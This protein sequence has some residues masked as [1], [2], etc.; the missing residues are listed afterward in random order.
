MKGT[1]AILATALSALLAVSALSGCSGPSDTGNSTG[2]ASDQGGTDKVRVA[3]LLPGET[4]DMGWS[5]QGYNGLLRA[6]EELGVEIA[7]AENI[8]ES[9]GGEYIRGYANDGY[10]IV[11]AHSSAYADAMKTVAPSFSDTWFVVTSTNVHEGENM[12][13]YSNDNAQQGFLA[14]VTAAAYTTSGKV[15]YIGGQET[16]PVVQKMNNAELGVSWVDDSV[17][18]TPLIMG[19]YDDLQLAQENTTAMIES[20]VDVIIANAD[21]ATATILQ[22]C[23]EKGV[24]CVALG[25]YYSEVYPDTQVADVI[26]DA[27]T[28][29]FQAISDYVNGSIKADYCLLGTDVDAVF[30]SNYGSFVS[31]DVKTTVDSALEALSAGSVELIY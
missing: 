13:A 30:V 2:G 29:V 26:N 25:D 8:S 9:D 24:A 27:A 16:T 10:D 22:V 23:Q 21:K 3:L 5:T 12:A 19:S 31:D 4:T 18:Y 11:I 7:Y 1:K 15:G 28:C 20:G 6:E 17:E 14:G